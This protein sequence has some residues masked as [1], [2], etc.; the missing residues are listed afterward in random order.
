[1]EEVRELDWGP[2]SWS[3][4]VLRSQ[5]RVLEEVG[6]TA[7][8]L[9]VQEEVPS[10]HQSRAVGSGAKNHFQRDLGEVTEE[11]WWLLHNSVQCVN[12]HV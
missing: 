8:A 9:C 4:K 6:N 2:W 10:L 1:M 12:C 5:R 7:A 3:V 11:M